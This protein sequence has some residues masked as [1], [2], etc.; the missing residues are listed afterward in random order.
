M[1][2]VKVN[3]IITLNSNNKIYGLDADGRLWVL[4]PD[5]VP[6]MWKFLLDS[7]EVPTAPPVVQPI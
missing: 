2:K 3:M 5:S 4:E 7:P 6:L 1:A